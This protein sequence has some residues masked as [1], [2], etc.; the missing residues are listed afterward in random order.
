MARETVRIYHGDK[1]ALK[2]EADWNATF[3]D[4]QGPAAEQIEEIKFTGK[5]KSLIDFLVAK[6][7]VASRTEVRR[8][9]SSKGIKVDGEPVSDESQNL[10]GGEM[11]QVGK[12]RFFKLKK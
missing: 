4:K 12:R 2:A 8:L 3:R 5:G 7:I 6:Q 1:A 11:I 9:I 10:K